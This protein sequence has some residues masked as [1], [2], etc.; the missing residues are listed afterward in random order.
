MDYR[1]EEL[2]GPTYDGL[3]WLFRIRDSPGCD[4][5]ASDIAPKLLDRQRKDR[6]AYWL[7]YKSAPPEPDAIT[8]H[9]GQ[10]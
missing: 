1:V 9:L 7:W 2:L 6:P 3:A 4:D 5:G 8:Y 10:S